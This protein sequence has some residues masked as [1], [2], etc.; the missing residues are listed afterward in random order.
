[1]AALAAAAA[2]KGPA[3]AAMEATSVVV[4]AGKIA[5]EAGVSGAVVDRGS[6]SAVTADL[7]VA[8]EAR[9]FRIILPDWEGHLRATGGTSPP[10]TICS[11]GA[12]ATGGSVFV[13]RQRYGFLYRYHRRWRNR[14][15]GQWGLRYSVGNHVLGQWRHCYRGR[16][17]SYRAYLF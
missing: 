4:A 11:A 14:Q 1:M 16:I 5:A 10:R 3:A 9:G 13:P 17:L 7:A 15:R 12:A 6:A 2:G 8:V